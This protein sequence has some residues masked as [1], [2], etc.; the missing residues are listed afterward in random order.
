MTLRPLLLWALPASALL[1]VPPAFKPGDAVKAAWERQPL[2]RDPA[3]LPEADAARLALIRARIGAPGAPALLP[4]ELEKPT[5]AA[6][7][8]K[9]RTA[10]T[11]QER[12]DA[13]FFLNRLRSSRALEALAGLTEA[14]AATWPARLQLTPFVAA[15][16]MNGGEAST[17]LQG[18]FAA[19]EQVGKV[20]ATRT[21]AAWLRL[22]RAGKTA[23]ARSPLPATPHGVLAM[24]DAWNT[25]PW[26]DRAEAHRTWLAALDLTRPTL[27]ALKAPFE[28][29]HLA[30]PTDPAQVGP[31]THALLHR[32]F[33]GLGQEA[34]MAPLPW[35]AALIP[36][37]KG[38]ETAA[39]ATLRS[40]YLGALGRAQAV[41]AEAL[42]PWLED[43]NPAVRAAV[44]PA[45]RK[46]APAE[47]DRLRDTWLTGKDALLR[48]AALED[49]AAPPARLET[50]A[51]RVLADD[52]LD[53]LQALVAC[54]ERWKLSPER[55]VPLLK[56]FLMHPDWGQRFTA[57]QA[58]VK[59]DPKI[60]WPA[61]PAP[62]KE[63]A[64][65]LKFAQNLAR[66]TTP[67]R[68]RLVFSGKRTVTLR[69]DPT[70]APLNVA[71][72]IRLARKRAFDGRQV[73]RVV[74]NFVVQMG[75]P[76]DTMDG[77]PGYTVRCENSLGWYGPGT[78]GMALSGKDTG[79]CQWFITLNATPHL[80][81]KYTRLGDVEDPEKALALLDQLELGAKIEKVQVLR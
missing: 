67:I 56:P 9:A 12:V 1:A 2:K 71:N 58:L 35:M 52:T 80:T 25:A 4:S 59:L 37:K 51:K 70:N 11:P 7:L 28:A 64:V 13:L 19:L 10:R 78:V 42:R 62:G 36:A 44:L 76:F 30:L 31:L 63:A 50:L 73:G 21:H 57:Y 22:K 41:P 55:Q 26:K 65:Q 14:D 66:E 47:A 46:A 3:G 23:E 77:G 61:A 69:L 40:A 53:T 74:P 72:F 48:N 27:E 39:T 75:S 60:P 32:L 33:E 29:L 8:E 17:A 79:G 20:D 38:Q 34:A 16:R 45:L 81:G 5:E 15:A 49:L 24:M 6:W 54:F 43:P 68:V 18:F